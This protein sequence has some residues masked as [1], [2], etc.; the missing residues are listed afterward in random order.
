MPLWSDILTELQQ[1]APNKAPDYDGVR[2]KYLSKL[3]CH[4]NNDVILYAS[5]WQQR[6]APVSLTTIVDED[7]HALMEVTS[8][9]KGPNVDLILHSPG[10]SP[11]AAEAIVSYL[12]SRFSKIRV[13]VPQLAMSAATMISC[14]ADEIV[15]G[16]HSFLGPTDP[17]FILATSLGIR[18]AGSCSGNPRPIRQ[19][20]ERVH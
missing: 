12:R 15:M 6:D 1:S 8:G 4:T 20:P 13:I 5:G 3:N 17:Q 10:G 19:S 14:A 18:Q 11:E 2:R 16:K 9:L 7:I